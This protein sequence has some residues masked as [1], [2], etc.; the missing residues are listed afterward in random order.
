M[1]ARFH[2]WN[3]AGSASR[4]IRHACRIGNPL[5]LAQMGGLSGSR[6]LSSAL[7]TGIVSAP[8]PV[9]SRLET[10]EVYTLIRSASARR[11]Q[12]KIFALR[13]FQA[14]CAGPMRAFTSDFAHRLYFNCPGCLKA[15][16]SLTLDKSAWLISGSSHDAAE[17]Q[18]R[19]T[20][21]S[22][23]AILI[24]MPS[25]LKTSGSVEYTRRRSASEEAKRAQSSAYLKHA[26]RVS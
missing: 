21:A 23:L 14:P 6:P 13:V 20:D 25:A 7:F 22:I 18:A 15:D 24:S 19:Y 8:L 9:S 16:V 17:T 12:R 2:S 26:M 11:L 3:L 5:D 10:N 1:K 4:C